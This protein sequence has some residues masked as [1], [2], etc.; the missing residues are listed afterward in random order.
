MHECQ[1]RIEVKID[2]VRKKILQRLELVDYK[3]PDKAYAPTKEKL[4]AFTV[5][6]L[7]VH[8]SFNVPTKQNESKDELIQR[9]LDYS[10]CLMYQFDEYALE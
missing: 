10:A 8:A 2:G 4:D 3:E 9:I 7:P 5:K 6:A 1:S